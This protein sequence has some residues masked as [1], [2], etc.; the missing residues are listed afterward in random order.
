MANARRAARHDERMVVILC[1][2]LF[3]M[4]LTAGAIWLQVFRML[5]TDKP[6]R[7]EN[8]ELSVFDLLPKVAQNGAG[9]AAPDAARPQTDAVPMPS[10][11][12][13]NDGV[14]DTAMPAKSRWTM[15]QLPTVVKRLPEEEP[16]V[17]L[18]FDD[19]PTKYLPAIVESLIEK[20][21]PAT[22]FWIGQYSPPAPELLEKMRDAQLQIGTHTV[23]HRRL[24][25][26]S[27]AAQ[28]KEIE[29]GLAKVAKW[30]GIDT[31]YVRPPYG[32][33]DEKTEKVA[34]EMGLKLVLWS[35]DPRDWEKGVTPGDIIE[36]VLSQLHPGAV[37]LLH[38]KE[39]TAQVLPE[40]IDRI[41]EQGYQLA[42]L[43][44]E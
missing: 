8:L 27:Y 16:Y 19:G 13:G 34:D 22:F 29:R 6:L 36:R 23:D 40:L 39:T 41:R 17:Y 43:P 44:Q 10:A 30:T 9:A 7:A 18:T 3:M 33:W 25:G 31:V 5:H 20:Q 24:A 11:D 15:A 14:L 32:A 35:V 4:V 26:Q 12:D 37:I 2:V 38:E 28:R 1:C 42:G 21:A